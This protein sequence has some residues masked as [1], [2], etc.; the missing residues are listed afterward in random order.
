MGQGGRSVA[1]P[2]LAW[3]GWIG[4]SGVWALWA[5]KKLWYKSSSKTRQRILPGVSATDI[6]SDKKGLLSESSSLATT[7][8]WRRTGPWVA[9]WVPALGPRGSDF[10]FTQSEGFILFHFISFAALWEFFP[11]NLVFL[12]E[13]Q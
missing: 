1:G 11:I 13:S 6:C 3:P 5:V 7:C 2:G 9:V 8:P 12:S 10:G 4:P